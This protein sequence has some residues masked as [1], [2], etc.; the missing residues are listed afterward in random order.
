M[1]S[2]VVPG[3]LFGVAHSLNKRGIR[4]AIVNHSDENL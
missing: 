3:P 1:N 4:L 2:N